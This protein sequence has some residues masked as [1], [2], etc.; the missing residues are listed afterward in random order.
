MP[1]HQQPGSVDEVQNGCS[2]LAVLALVSGLGIIV[3]RDGVQVVRPCGKNHCDRGWGAALGERVGLALSGGGARGAYEAGVLSVLLPELQRR[4]E[5]PTVL[6]GTSAGALN[7]AS[8]AADADKDAEQAAVRLVEVW[9]RLRLGDVFHSIARK[10]A[11]WTM[12]R[13]A[14]EVLGVPGVRLRALLDPAPLRDSIDSQIDWPTVHRNVRDGTLE[15]LA[16]A[17]SPAANPRNTIFVEHQGRP[18]LPSRRTI[19]YVTTTL[20]GDHLMASAAIPMLFPAVQ[21]HQP[22]DSAGWYYDGSARLNTP[23]DPALELGVDRLVVVG[24]H[25]IAPLRSELWAA[26]EKD[27]DLADGALQLLTATLTAPMIDDVRRLGQ[28][29]QL[30]R[31]A[32]EVVAAHRKAEKKTP[33]RQ[34]PY[35]YIAPATRGELGDIAS[36]VFRRRYHGYRAFTAPDLAILSRL[37]GGES[38]QHGELISYLLFEGEFLN[39]TI[40]LGERDARRWL[41]RVPAPDAPWYLAHID[42]LPDS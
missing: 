37:L 19:E 15:C 12:G 20:S 36:E 24:T 35:M 8:L 10:Q 28:V 26:E 34:V 27:P 6:V 18:D 4:G 31:D 32:N 33:Y 14:G 17:A 22:A 39:E 9:R 38:E 23:L 16:V 30:L 21:I 13:Y 2:P 3:A 29:N 42:T 11:P 5:R 25:S 7:A 1:V 41:D 40:A